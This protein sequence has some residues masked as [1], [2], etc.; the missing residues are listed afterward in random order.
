M[1]GS[2]ALT[3]QLADIIDDIRNKTTPQT[4]CDLKNIER[5]SM[6][7]TLTLKYSEYFWSKKNQIDHIFWRLTNLFIHE[8][9]V[10]SWLH[11]VPSLANLAK[12]AK[13][14]ASVETTLKDLLQL[15]EK[16]WEKFFE[17][18]L[19]EKS[20]S[21]CSLS[22]LLSEISQNFQIDLKKESETMYKSAF[23]VLRY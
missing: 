4:N 7:E 19:V 18:N 3:L 14:S 16:R 6:H 15:C 13:T 8:I 23:N 22:I 21:K 17:S 20:R 11:L 5:I 10:T 2:A 1:E 12:I 9:D